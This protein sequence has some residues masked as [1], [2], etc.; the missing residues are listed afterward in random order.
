MSKTKPEKPIYWIWGNYYDARIKWESIKSEYKDYVLNDIEC[1]YEPKNSSKS[2]SIASVILSLKSRDLFDSKPRLF[3][4]YGCPPDI[5]ILYE[6][7][8]L[9]NEDNVVVIYAP[10]G[11]SVPAGQGSR[12]CTSKTTNLYKQIK[13]WNHIFD[14]PIEAN[15]NN[16]A[17]KWTIK[18]LGDLNLEIDRDVA[19]VLV[20]F[21]GKNLDILYSEIEKLFNLC[22][23]KVVLED[24]KKYCISEFNRTVWDLISSLSNMDYDLSMSHLCYFYSYMESQNKGQFIGEINKLLGALEHNYT[25]ANLV[26]SQSKGR[27]SYDSMTKAVKDIKK[28]ELKDKKYTYERDLFDYPIIRAKINDASFKDLVSAGDRLNDILLDLYR[29]SMICRLSNSDE[30]I[31]KQSL[32]VFCLLACGKISL[33]GAERLRSKMGI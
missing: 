7:M 11:Y 19:E 9:V 22:K 25:F 1:G 8:H 27:L 31:I 33:S 15:S 21:K 18:V 29:C 3:R 30:T 5:S 20:E 32:N 24:I 26:S 16:E 4:I 23:K 17:I 12:F 10:F 14:Y 2:M 13:S 28:R 6:Y